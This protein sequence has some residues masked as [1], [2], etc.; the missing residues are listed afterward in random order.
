L[1][2]INFV[3]KINFI[4]QIGRIKMVLSKVIFTAAMMAAPVVVGAATGCVLGKRAKDVVEKH[5]KEVNFGGAVCRPL[6]E[7]IAK[8][9]S[10]GAGAA[11]FVG[12]AYAGY[13]ACTLVTTF[14]L[15][16]GMLLI[17]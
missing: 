5:F 15:P 6:K 8:R 13:L 1:I 2:F 10:L 16:V 17:R 9:L 14:A 11:G 7:G 4:K 12:G 3:C